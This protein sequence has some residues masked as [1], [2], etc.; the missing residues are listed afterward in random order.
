MK[1]HWEKEKEI[2]KKIQELKETI[3][4][5]RSEEQKAEREGN[6][7]KVAQ[8]RYGTLIQLKEGLEQESNSLN[9]LQKSRKM[10]KEEVDAEDIAEVVAKWTGIPVSRMMEGEL[11]KLVSMEERIKQRV[12]GQEEAIKA[13]SN[14]VRRSRSG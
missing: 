8:I 2:I 4:H 9:E 5:T 7:E 14:A 10:L 13:V 3:E 11:E 6:L 12:I 1:A